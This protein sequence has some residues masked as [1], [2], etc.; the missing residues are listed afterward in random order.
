M[1]KRKTTDGSG[2]SGRKYSNPRLNKAQEDN[3]RIQNLVMSE[4]ESERQIYFLISV[5]PKDCD[6]ENMTLQVCPQMDEMLAWIYE[7][8]LNEWSSVNDQFM[9]WLFAEKT[10][11]VPEKP[12]QHM[13]FRVVQSSAETLLNLFSSVRPSTVASWFHLDCFRWEPLLLVPNQVFGWVDLYFAHSE[14][15]NLKM[16]KDFSAQHIEQADVVDP[17]KIAFNRSEWIV[18]D[19]SR[20]KKS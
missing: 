9:A 18:Q 8:L 2:S 6:K 5:G 13:I 19:F 20:G 3:L 7:G 17:P 11:E 15:V 1:I 12:L 10:P 16:T 14:L 4:P